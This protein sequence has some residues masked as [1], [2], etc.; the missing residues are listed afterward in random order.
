MNPAAADIVLGA[1]VALAAALPREEPLLLPERRD[2]AG[3]LRRLWPGARR[4]AEETAGLEAEDFLAELHGEPDLTVRVS[5]LPSV[6]RTVECVPLPE[7]AR[8]P[9]RRAPFAP[10]PGLEFRSPVPSRPK[11]PPTVVLEKVRPNISRD[12]GLYL[13]SLRSYEEESGPE[14]GLLS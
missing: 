13:A 2:W 11:G 8:P 14:P 1:A 7:D 6:Q 12:L 9:W 3:G 5:D 4:R 10:D